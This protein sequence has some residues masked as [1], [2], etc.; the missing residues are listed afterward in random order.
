MLELATQFYTH[1]KLQGFI[2]VVIV[3]GSMIAFASWV[4]YMNFGPPSKRGDGRGPK[5]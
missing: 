3:C 4:A 1:D 2:V 5:P